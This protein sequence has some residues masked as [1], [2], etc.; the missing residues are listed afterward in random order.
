[1][2]ACA[3]RQLGAVGARPRA[4]RRER[5]L[6]AASTAAPPTQFLPLKLSDWNDG[7]DVDLLHEEPPVYLVRNVLTKEQCEDLIAAGE[8]GVLEQVEYEQAVELDM[9]RLKLLA[10]LAAVAGVPQTLSALERGGGA[11]DAFLAFFLSAAAFG[12]FALAL[13]QA[14]RGAV[15]ARTPRVFSGTKWDA[16]SGSAGAPSWAATCAFLDAV[17]RLTG[18]AYTCAEV[19]TLT[20]YA[21]G[22][23]QRTHIDARSAGDGKGAEFAS[24]GGQRLV[25]VV[26]LE[27]VHGGATSFSHPA[28]RGL[29]VQPSEGDALVFFPAFADGTADARMPHA[30]EPVLPDAPDKWNLNTWVCEREVQAWE[31]V[32]LRVVTTRDDGES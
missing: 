21:P 4:R 11:G 27:P 13:A 32:K 24:S 12:G 17:E 1:M 15:A 23:E 3:R 10:P 28:L 9:E 29:R 8:S 18:R 16:S 7:A 19:P 20:R 14:V 2:Q 30:G 25:Q 5:C 31:N 6:V 22:E 26:A